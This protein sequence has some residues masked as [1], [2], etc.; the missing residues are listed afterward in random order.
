[1]ERSIIGNDNRPDFLYKNINLA[2]IKTRSIENPEK[3]FIKF[4]G[5]LSPDRPNLR[6]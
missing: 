4:A 5:K 6:C 1:M 2:G 3:L